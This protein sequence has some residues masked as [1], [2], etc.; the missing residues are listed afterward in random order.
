[1]KGHF[2]GSVNEVG[3]SRSGG[4]RS[5]PERREPRKVSE[6]VIA[7][8]GLNPPE[9]EV[10]AKAKRRTFSAKYKKKILD[11]VDAAKDDEGAIGKIL[12]GEGLYS[13]HLTTWRKQR[14]NGELNGLMPK[15]RG[16][17][18]NP[19]HPLIEKVRSLE[20]ENRRLRMRL[21][22]AETIIEFQK[23]ISE[24]LGMVPDSKRR[25]GTC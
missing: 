5:E 20:S 18:A 8:A 3:G 24:M 22:K 11:R 12:R 13:S 19:A 10:I 4:E 14:E 17:K 6:G 7:F 9:T 15:A 23:K 16:K 21:Q 1:M 2:E 25:T